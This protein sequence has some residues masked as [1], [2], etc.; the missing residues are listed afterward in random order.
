MW[1]SVTHQTLSLLRIEDRQPTNS[2]CLQVSRSRFRLTLCTDYGAPRSRLHTYLWPEQER[3]CL[4][5]LSLRPIRRGSSTPLVVPVGGE[6]SNVPLLHTPT[7]TS[8]THV[9]VQYNSL[10]ALRRDVVVSQIFVPTGLL[11]YWSLQWPSTQ[12][13]PVPESPWVVFR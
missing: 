4:R 10:R 8:L 11:P 13:H 2:S 9:W 5:T 6:V 3:K 12:T 7:G 1:Q